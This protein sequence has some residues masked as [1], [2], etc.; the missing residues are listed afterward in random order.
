[1]KNSINCWDPVHR[2]L[3]V[4]TRHGWECTCMGSP[5][6]KNVIVPL[7]RWVWFFLQIKT[8][9]AVY[10]TESTCLFLIWQQSNDK[11]KLVVIPENLKLENSLVLLYFLLLK[12]QLSNDTLGCEITFLS[13]MSN[14]SLRE[15]NPWI[16]Q[17][18]WCSWQSLDCC[19]CFNKS[20]AN[21]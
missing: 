18:F 7:T 10:I 2:G 1:M 4:I 3:I 16:L 20:S 6:S 5:L 12:G 19:R 9:Q 8:Q 13:W 15:E 17:Q 21:I 11:K 14:N